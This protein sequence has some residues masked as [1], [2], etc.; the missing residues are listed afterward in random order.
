VV[1]GEKVWL[2]GLRARSIGPSPVFLALTARSI[3]DA[4]FCRVFRLEMVQLNGPRRNDYLVQEKQ[5]IVAAV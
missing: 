3:G 4:V 1:V 2:H 5:L